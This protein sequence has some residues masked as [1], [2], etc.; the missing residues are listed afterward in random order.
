MPA[1]TLRKVLS[2]QLSDAM[3]SCGMKGPVRQNAGSVGSTVV[4]GHTVKA[5]GNLI[6]E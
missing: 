1:G 3:T 5:L 6:K 4:F 2:W